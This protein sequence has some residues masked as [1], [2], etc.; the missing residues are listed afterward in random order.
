MNEVGADS[1]IIS[2]SWADDKEPEWRKRLLPPVGRTE[3]QEAA[4]LM[5]PQVPSVPAFASRGLQPLQIRDAEIYQPVGQVIDEVRELDDVL[6]DA[7]SGE[8]LRR[9]GQ[10]SL[11]IFPRIEPLQLT[12]I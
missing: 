2:P 11:R 4:Y 6:W 3:M 7:A 9:K 10:E 1:R 12:N 5:N 8:L